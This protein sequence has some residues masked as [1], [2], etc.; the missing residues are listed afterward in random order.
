MPYVILKRNWPGV[1]RR[2]VQDKKGKPETLVF[3]PGVPVNLTPSQ[4]NLLSKEIG[5]AIVPVEMDPK[6]RPK[7]ILEDVAPAE[8]TENESPATDA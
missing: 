2:T 5:T 8:Q 6:K 3:E 1:F 4:V 7:L